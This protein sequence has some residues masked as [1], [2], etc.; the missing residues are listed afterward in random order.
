MI[1]ERNAE[2]ATITV[3]DHGP[4]V[5]EEF[6]RQI[7]EPFFRGDEAREV[8]SGGVGL[9]LSIARRAVQLHE[10]TIVAENAAQHC[11]C[12]SRFP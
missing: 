5:P 7:L 11:E 9:E 6:L 12:E 2:F 10:G 4:E 1:L 3:R 8:T